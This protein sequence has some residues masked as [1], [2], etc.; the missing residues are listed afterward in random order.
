[1]TY[2]A[3]P[4]RFAGRTAIA[5]IRAAHEDLEAGA[6]SGTSYRLAGRVM[7]RRGQG[8]LV[9][10]DLV[11]RSGR[12]QLL[13]ALDVLGEELLERVGGISLGDV[14]GVEGEAIAHAARRAV[15]AP[16]GLRAAGAEPAA[17]ARHL[18][19]AVRRRGALPPALPRPADVAR[20]PRA[21]RRPVARRLGVPPVPRRPR[22]PRGRDAGAA[23]ALRRRAGPAVHHAPQRARPRPVP[24]HRHRAVP[25]AAHR[26]RAREGVRARQGLPQRGRVVQAQPRVHDARDVRGVRRLRGRHAHDGGDGRATPRRRRSAR[27]RSSGRASRST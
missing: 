24:A 25:E 17:A 11:D 20:E 10:L 2:D 16:D 5:D 9:F 26:R 23:A 19:R 22:L 15:A 4:H 8:K 1:M 3:L 18:A 7:A 27:P 12:L 21:V 13:A 6:E 14:V